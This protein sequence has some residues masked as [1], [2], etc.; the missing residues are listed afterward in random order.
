VD[1]MALKTAEFAAYVDFT[2]SGV[3]SKFGSG[4]KLS[5]R[6]ESLLLSFVLDLINHF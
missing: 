5:S 4:S 3:L 1:L 2:F 6:S